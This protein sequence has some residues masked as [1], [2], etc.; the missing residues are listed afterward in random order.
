LEQ[1]DPLF[2]KYPG[3]N[4]ET[5]KIFSETETQSEHSPNTSVE[6]YHYNNLLGKT[7]ANYLLHIVTHMP[8]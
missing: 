8:I 1:V 5:T 7:A 2:W 3:E 6:R 4:E